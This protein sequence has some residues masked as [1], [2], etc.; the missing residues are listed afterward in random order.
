[1]YWL[2]DGAN[3]GANRYSADPYSKSFAYEANNANLTYSVMNLPDGVTAAD[4]RVGWAEGDNASSWPVT[5][6][7]KKSQYRM[8]D[9]NAGSFVEAR[10]VDGEFIYQ[11]EKT[12]EFGTHATLWVEKNGYHDG[13]I[14][15]GGAVERDFHEALRINLGYATVE[16]MRE[17]AR[18][19]NGVLNVQYPRPGDDKTTIQWS[20]PIPTNIF[21]LSIQM[22]DDGGAQLNFPNTYEQHLRSGEG[23]KLGLVVLD[24]T[25]YL[26]ISPHIYDLNPVITNSS[27]PAWAFKALT[28]DKLDRTA[29]FYLFNPKPKGGNSMW[30]PPKGDIITMYEPPFIT[31]DIIAQNQLP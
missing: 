18:T 1:V 9:V 24:G 17:E 28:L 8:F 10:P 29:W 16:E 21:E 22:A 7:W 19:H 6:F 23:E 30:N 31:A 5:C 11:G 4:L 25:L 12:Y 3:A 2:T 20:D 13:K 26:Q 14:S 27:G 15:L